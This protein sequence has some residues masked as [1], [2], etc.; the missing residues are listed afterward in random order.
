M[1]TSAKTIQA[2]LWP[3]LGTPKDVPGFS[4]TDFM[5]L[6]ARSKKSTV[7]GPF[8]QSENN[9]KFSYEHSDDE[10]IDYE[11]CAPPE[12]KSSFGSAIAEALNNASAHDKTPKNEGNG[13]TK[14]GRNKKKKNV[15]KTLLF[16]TGCR[17]FDGN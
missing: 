9:H 12:F 7:H 8:C 10:S 6:Q 3:T 2:E 15:G 14:A 17:T 11:S 16:S 4:T 5:P 13:G 1:L